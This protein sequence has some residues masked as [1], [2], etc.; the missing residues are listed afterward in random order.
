M[1]IYKKV[2][3][4]LS[5]FVFTLNASEFS[6]LE[7]TFKTF[8]QENSIPGASLAIIKDSR[9]VYAKGFGWADRQLKKPVEVNSL[10]RIASLSK[11]ITAVAILQ[12]VEQENISLNDKVVSLLKVKPYNNRGFIDPRW[13]EITVKHLLQHEG[14]WSRDNDIMGNIKR[15][16]QALDKSTQAASRDFIRYMMGQRLEFTPGTQYSYSNFGYNILGRIIEDVTNMSY[17]H[18]V[19][20]NILYPL[21]IYTMKLGK[22]DKQYRAKEEVTY[23]DPYNK[24][25]SP[26]FGINKNRKVPVAYV[27]TIDVQDSHG[28]WIASASDMA[29]FLSCFD[30]AKGC[31]IIQTKTL[32]YM[33]KRQEG[34]ACYKNSQA[35]NPYYAH[36]W[37]VWPKRMGK[38]IYYFGALAGTSTSMVRRSD[39]IGWVVL[40]NMRHNKDYKQLASLIDG[41]LHKVMNK[42]QAWPQYDLFKSLGYK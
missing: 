24:M 37:M 18:Y 42:I 16:T 3:Y 1:K 6:E 15:V 23:Y 26:V 39:G 22:R 17:E 27:N 8:M 33:F 9:L 32:E 35:K 40:F 13:Q 12:L 21:G 25:G 19:Q 7:Q 4:L 14:G 31:A 20:A 36:G 11:S 28:G 29:R 2:L 34:L 10:F 41:K 38:N 30:K 5:I